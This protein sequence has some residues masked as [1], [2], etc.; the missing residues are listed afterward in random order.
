[1]AQETERS[2]GEGTGSETYWEAYSD[3][4]TVSKRVAHSVDEAL[5]AYATLESH[6]LEGAQMSPGKAAQIRKRILSAALRLVVELEEE[7]ESKN[8]YSDILERWRGEDEEDDG[9][10]KQ[11]RGVQLKD[12]MPSFLLQMIIDIRRAAWHL[13]YIQAGRQSRKELPDRTEEDARSM[14]EGS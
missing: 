4:Q 14:F 3:Y 11:L 2:N 7:E 12:T 10:I 13:G 5:D 8:I 9:F 6:H 1:M